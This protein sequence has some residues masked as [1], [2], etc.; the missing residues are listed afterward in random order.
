MH[1]ESHPCQADKAPWKLADNMKQHT[2]QNKMILKVVSWTQFN[3]MYYNWLFFVV[4]IFSYTENVRYK[5]WGGGG[6]ITPPTKSKILI[7]K[8]KREKEEGQR[9]GGEQGLVGG[10]GDILKT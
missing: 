4:K 2:T 8:R 1:S 10:W 5:W 7:G 6:E 3:C 9:G